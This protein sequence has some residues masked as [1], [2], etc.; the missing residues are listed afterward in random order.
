[1]R[2]RIVS[3]LFVYYFWIVFEGVLRK[4][5]F[6]GTGFQD[7]IIL[8][9]DLIALFIYYKY[10]LS[11]NKKINIVACLLTLYIILILYITQLFIHQ[12]SFIVFSIGIRYYIFHIPIIF[13]MIGTMRKND[14]ARFI[15]YNIYLSVFIAILCV[16]QHNSPVDHDINRALYESKSIFTISPDIVRTYGTFSF[17][18]G[19]TI[20]AAI[21][22][23]LCLIYI[24]IY[25]I[26]YIKLSIFLAS[27]ISIGFTTG[28]RSYFVYFSIIILLFI[29]TIINKDLKRKSIANILSFSLVFTIS[30]FLSIYIYQSAYESLLFRFDDA[31][32]S[33]G[34]FLWPRILKMTTEF[35]TIM[36]AAGAFGYG[37]G[38]GS[39]AGAYVAH[40]ERIFAVKENVWT[41]H[42]LEF[43]VIPGLLLIGLRM[44]ATFWFGL[45]A[46]RVLFRG[47]KGS[48]LI[49]FGVVGPLLFIGQFMSQNTLNGFFWFIFGLFLLLLKD[50]ETATSFRSA[51]PHPER[52][53]TAD[54]KVSGQNAV[55]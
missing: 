30:T 19:N 26:N 20:Y 10:F 9:R 25:K 15:D 24:N 41:G 49:L 53:I 35:T 39:N 23:A 44:A 29:I 14:V 6:Y 52:M 43:G 16:F 2:G 51:R 7:N 55:I 22:L 12:S 31:A 4:W 46:L 34:G 36:D 5:V 42:I 21:I 3:L 27:V 11:Y 48:A 40:G 47:G 28:S 13:V 8:I 33:E 45:R 38:L 32:F 18:L 50:E 1:M 37:I 54:N 17:T